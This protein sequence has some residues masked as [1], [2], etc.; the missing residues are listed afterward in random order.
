VRANR[1]YATGYALVAAA[2]EATGYGRLRKQALAGARGT[3]LIVGLGPGHDLAHLPP[4]V[5]RVIAIEPDAAMRHRGRARVRAARVP[6]T[7]VG[8]AAEAI[9]LPD[10]AVDCA[11]VALVLCS[12]D[13]PAAV[14]AELHRVIRPAGTL[15]VLEH[16]LAPNGGRTRRWQQRLD[17]FWARM[18][19][20]CRLTRDPRGELQAAGFDTC[21]L[22]VRAAPPPVA[23]Q[24]IGTAQRLA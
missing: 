19:A 24:L 22:R 1:W 20:G 7:V 13:D 23:D 4:E 15:H 16:V 8:A 9:P 11:L 5:T 10:R 12:V 14:A 3:L 18:A 21:D 6:V 17:P 2:G